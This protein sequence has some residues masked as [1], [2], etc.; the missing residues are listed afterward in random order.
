MWYNQAMTANIDPLSQRIVKV[1]FPISLIRRMDEAVIAG[2]GGF[3]TRMELMREAVENLLNELEFPEAGAEP[4]SQGVTVSPPAEPDENGRPSLID[5]L[6]AAV[7]VWER[8]ELALG[9]LAA[10][11]L[12]PPTSAPQLIVSGAASVPDGP[13]LGLHNRDYVSIWALHRLARYTEGGPIPQDD[14]LRRVTKA[15]WFFG[16]QLRGLEARDLG[17][18]LTVLLPTNATKQ[19]SAERGFQ[20]FAVG[21][22]G[23]RSEDG[24]L[25]ATGPL[26]AWQ[27]I[28]VEM[29]DDLT[30]G[31]T[32]HGWQ[33]LRD[34]DGLSLDL[35]HAPDLMSR[36]LGYLAN[37]AP[38]DSWGFDHLLEVVAGGPDREALVASFAEGH[39][40]WTAS[41]ASS[42]A[43]GY[44]ARAREWGLVEPTLVEGR[45]WL[46]DVGRD[47]L[48][49]PAATIETT[50]DIHGRNIA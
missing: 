40:E 49:N 35:P 11:A 26:F 27:A 4:G 42:I 12:R 36:F 5:E 16:A 8:E 45:Y 38:G 29:M 2:R 20:S 15:A 34:L 13:L 37:H 23:R 25:R 22:A 7:P 48:R 30:V 17:R 33:L 50:S 10:T 31:L 24:S 18:K 39:P 6:V 46:T 44:V 43:Q 47:R 32:D 14:Y 1:P 9:D 41:T 3:Q 28:Q 19:P 21:S